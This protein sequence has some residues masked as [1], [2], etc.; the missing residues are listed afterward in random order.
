LPSRPGNDATRRM[1]C[2]ARISQ[3]HQRVDAMDPAIP[4]ASRPERLRENVGT[5]DHPLTREQRAELDELF[6]PPELA[7]YLGAEPVTRPISATGP[8]E[9]LAWLA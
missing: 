4:K 7:I 1:G 2:Q 9:E 5:F 3:A 6:P 8:V